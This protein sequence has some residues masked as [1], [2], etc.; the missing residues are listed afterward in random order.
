MAALTT[1]YAMGQVPNTAPDWRSAFQDL[2]REH[3]FEPLRVEGRIPDDLVGTLYRNGPALF[4]MFG[5]RYAHWFDGDGAI[6]AVRFGP[7]GARGAARL[8]QT[9]GLLDERRAG[10][11]IYAG[12]GSTNPGNALQRI[13]PRG[14][15]AANTSVVIWQGQLLRPVRRR[16]ADRYRPR[17]PLHAR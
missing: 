9:K 3:G 4:S 17:R 13:M 11:A 14:K 2:P 5:R 10:R 7:D 8:V 1:I 16:Q 6:S 15:N 12:Y